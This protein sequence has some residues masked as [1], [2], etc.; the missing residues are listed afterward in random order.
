PVSLK[1]EPKEVALFDKDASV[2]LK[3]QALDKNGKE[4]KKVKYE[5]VSQNSSV[6]TVDNTGKITATGSGETAIEIR[7][8]KISEIVPVKVN[9]AEVLKIEFPIAGVFDIQGP[10]KSVHKLL[11]TAKN[12]K[13]QDIDL[14]LLKFSSSDTNVATVNENGEI[15]LLNDGKTV[16][17]AQL[18]KKKATL[19]IPV[20]ILRPS[21]VKVDIPRF[22]INVGETAYLPF[23]VISTKGTTLIDFPVKVDFEQQGI[24]TADEVGKVT[25]VAKGTTKVTI[26]AGE[27]SNTL[28]LTVK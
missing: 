26:T 16:V 25:G 10:E 3:I 5:F 2:S 4:I 28:T 1:V 14:S 17:S 11:V 19:E 8:K 7:T 27:S 18:G 20:T 15:T 9:I 23:S 21:A 6:A 22:S 24:A 12:E 13:G